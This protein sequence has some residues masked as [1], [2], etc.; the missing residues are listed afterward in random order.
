M[1]LNQ[2]SKTKKRL[3]SEQLSFLKSILEAEKKKLIFNGVYESEEFNLDIEDKS[4]EVDQANA[5]VSNSHRLRFRNREV[6]YVKKLDSALKRME[7]NE[8]GMC[9]ECEEPIRFE[10]L[11]ARPTA[12]YCIICK[13]ESERDESSSILGRQSKSLGKAISIIRHF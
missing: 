2:A 9:V 7:K 13:E 6:F 4:D 1:G 5:D 10:R 12:D 3:T 8:Y 11:K